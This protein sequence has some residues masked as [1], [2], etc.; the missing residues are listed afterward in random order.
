MV[1]ELPSPP[2]TAEQ[3]AGS[4]GGVL[5]VDQ[6]RFDWQEEGTDFFGC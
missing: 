1:L 6:H 2:R 3:R 4:G 5:W